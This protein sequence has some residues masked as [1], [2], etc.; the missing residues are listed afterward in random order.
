VQIKKESNE[1]TEKI[2][3]L[4]L[5][6]EQAAKALNVTVRT[7]YDLRKK[8]AIHSVVLRKKHLYSVEMLRAFSN[9]E[10][11]ERWKGFQHAVAET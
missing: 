7:L 4:L 2:Q 1:K 5:T 9:G 3:P 8:G 11:V 10:S 6:S